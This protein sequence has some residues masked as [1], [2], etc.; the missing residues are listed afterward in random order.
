MNTYQKIKSGFFG[1]V[2]SRYLIGRKL[3]L[4]FPDSVDGKV[5][6]LALPDWKLTSF[7]VKQSVE[8]TQNE[9]PAQGQAAPASVL[10]ALVMGCEGKD[11]V[12]LAEFY[13]Q[14]AALSALRSVKRKFTKPWR[15]ALAV[16]AG[17]F[18]LSAVGELAYVRMSDRAGQ[19]GYA[20]GGFAKRGLGMAP[21]ALPAGGLPAG[22]AAGGL[23]AGMAA[24][25]LPQAP[26]QPSMAAP[27]T[28]EG[29]QDL[30]K[31]RYGIDI[32]QVPN[33]KEMLEQAAVQAQAAA[34]GQ[35]AKPGQAPTPAQTQYDTA[36]TIELLQKSK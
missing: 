11:D 33:G 35:V 31:K 27:T 19:Q 21:G 3:V 2:K 20:A 25:G 7:S 6:I 10:W 18:M 13:D 34:A 24:G 32:S 4:D 1:T 8:E 30:I 16:L 17:I 36:A 15:T 29:M 14:K 26:R 22:M 23:P 9:A 5:S 28:A 12:I